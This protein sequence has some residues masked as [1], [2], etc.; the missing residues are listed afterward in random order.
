MTNSVD[1]RLQRTAEQSAATNLRRRS[2][3]DSSSTS[4]SR[5]PSMNRPAT[6]QYL[7]II[8]YEQDEVGDA[9][10]RSMSKMK[11][12]L[13]QT[14]TISSELESEIKVDK[15]A[16]SMA[17]YSKLAGK[18][19][20]RDQALQERVAQNLS[21]SKK[22][23][24]S[25]DA[26]SSLQQ[27]MDKLP[28]QLKE[29]S[30]A[31]KDLAKFMV[32]NLVN[33]TDT[34]N[35][36]AGLERDLAVRQISI[37]KTQPNLRM[38]QANQ[39]IL[40]ASLAYIQSNQPEVLA[41]LKSDQVEQVQSGSTTAQAMTQY[42]HQ[43]LNE[44]PDDSTYLDIFK[45]N[46]NG[47][48][49]SD[50]YA[51]KMSE[52]IAKRIH[53]L[54]SQAA[55][56]AKN[57]N[58]IKLSPEEAE[59][60]ARTVRQA[61]QNLHGGDTPRSLERIFSQI[62]SQ[63][64]AT[65]Q[66]QTTGQGQ[67]QAQAP[68]PNQ[69]ASAQAQKPA[70]LSNTAVNVDPTDEMTEQMLAQVDRNTKNENVR[71]LSLAELSARA[72][73]L[74]QQF[75]AERQRL[76]AEGKLPNPAQM[77]Q[78]GFERQQQAANVLNTTLS[79]KDSEPQPLSAQQQALAQIKANTQA[80]NAA[81]QKAQA[82]ID[83]SAAQ[84][85]QAQAQ[86][87][88]QA[89][90]RPAS[91]TITTQPQAQPQPQAQQAQGQQA[92][93]SQPAQS[94]APATSSATATA[95]APETA[96]A[97]PKGTIAQQGSQPVQAQP[98]PQAQAQPQVHEPK[99]QAPAA[100]QIAID[101][102]LTTLTFD[103]NSLRNTS[104]N[105]SYNAV[106]S[107]IYGG[108]DIMPGMTIPVSHF[109]DLS[110]EVIQP[111]QK[112]INALKQQAQF[113]ETLAQQ[114]QAPSNKGETVAQSQVQQPTHPVV[115]DGEEALIAKQPVQ[116]APQQA[117][118]T[119]Q[120]VQQ[121]VAAAKGSLPKGPLA[122]EQQAQQPAQPQVQQPARPVVADGEETLVAKQPVQ[123]APQQAQQPQQSVQQQVAA[124]Q[125]SLPKGPV[126]TEQQAQQPA[127]PQVQQPARPVVADGEEALVAKQ[128]VQQAPQQQQPQQSV[129]QQVAAA[130]GSLPKGHIATEQQAQQPAAQPQVQQPA[131]PVV[132][133]GEET[134][135]A[136]QP[137]Q[138][139]PQQQQPHQSVQQQV[140]AAQG[141][142]P[143]GHIA[144]EQQ[145]QQPAQPQV[146]QPA[147]PVV[148]DGE[149]TLVA[150]QPV[151]QAPQQAQQP[152]QQQPQQSVQQQVAAAQDALPKGPIATEQQAQ[153]Q[154]PAVQPQ[155]QQA[156][157]QPQQ[158]AAS[159]PPVTLANFKS[160]MYA[161]LYGQMQKQDYEAAQI[162]QPT[163][164][165][166]ALHK[167]MAQVQ[168]DQDV[169][170]DTFNRLES[171]I[172]KRQAQSTQGA[173]SAQGNQGAGAANANAN[174]N[175]LNAIPAKAQVEFNLDL[176]V[177]KQLF[178]NSNT[179]E[180]EAESVF[181]AKQAAS[182]A[183]ASA[184]ASGTEALAAEDDQVLA[185]NK[186]PH[187]AGERLSVAET[188]AALKQEKA[189][190]E[191]Q[192]Q[193]EQNLRA[194]A[195]TIANQERESALMAPSVVLDEQAQ[196]QGLPEAIVGTATGQQA[197]LAGSSAPQTANTA[198]DSSAL[199]QAPNPAAPHDADDSRMQ[200]LYEHVQQNLNEA[201]NVRAEAMQTQTTIAQER[202]QA[203]IL[204]QQQQQQQAQQQQ[205]VQAAADDKYQNT[206][207]QQAQLT[208]DQRATGGNTVGNTTIRATGTTLARAHSDAVTSQNQAQ[209][210]TTQVEART[211]GA[212]ATANTVTAEARA[213]QATVS[214][215]AVQQT[216][217]HQVTT[218]QTPA[219]QV[220]AQSQAPTSA[221]SN[222]ASAQSA[223][224]PAQ[225]TT[226]ASM[227]TPMP[228][229]QGSA[230]TANA[231]ASAAP[232]T[233]AA[234][235]T[236]VATPNAATMVP[237]TATGASNSSTVAGM[238]TT[239]SP[240]ISG[241]TATSGVGALGSTTSVGSTT[242]TASATGTG[243]AAGTA[244]ANGTAAMMNQLSGRSSQHI[245]HADLDEESLQDEIIKNVM[246]TVPSDELD[247]FSLRN[248]NI[249][250]AALS[251]VIADT[252]LTSSAESFDEI[253][254]H[255]QAMP[256]LQS[257]ATVVP[258]NS[259]PG[260]A[261]ITAGQNA[262]IPDESVIPNMTTPKEGGGLLRRLAS[263]FG[264][265]A[266]DSAETTAA[267][268]NQAVSSTG[269][270]I[271]P[272]ERT[273][274]Q[275]QIS[276]AQNAQFSAL[277]QL[278]ARLQGASQDPALPP[279]MQE[280]AQKLLRALQNPVADL[281]S[282]SNWLNFITGPLSPSSSQALALHQW[283]FMLLCIRFEQIGKNVER[284]LKKSSS[285]S[286][287]KE[288]DGSIKSNRGLFESLNDDGLQKSQ[289]LLKDTFNQ[290]ERLQQQMQAVP[291]GQVLPRVIPLPPYYHGG[292][293]GSMSAHR[294]Q[295]ED[296]GTSWNLNFNLDLENMG[297]L[298]IKVRL[299]FPEVQMSFVAE[300]LETLQ[301]VQENMPILNARLQEVGL[302][303]KG[304]NARLGHVSLQDSRANSGSESKSDFK[305]EGASFNTRA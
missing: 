130:Q 19:I 230:P 69:A 257:T 268:T 217:A 11:Q 299:R 151:Q 51:D 238:G 190:A 31:G 102:D 291:T 288:L 216:P 305:F 73:Q 88:A 187:R 23:V 237:S 235:A 37:P 65:T 87:Q 246:Q 53:D 162:K 29:G 116:Q 173:P 39:K 115:A 100:P 192:L 166:P 220:A 93:T 303:S 34:K 229:A 60:F 101:N 258:T 72:A 42:L 99:G 259:T 252:D 241:L 156:P 66:A 96:Q 247:A 127:Q 250:N 304:S 240:E 63:N 33:L 144:T 124:A 281:Q 188:V 163:V 175:G 40:A 201:R 105:L 161:R 256:P 179:I 265:R 135:V 32:E 253:L 214:Q 104:I 273:E 67:A 62:N 239:A 279:Q 183:M 47:Q 302:T 8:S 207:Q 263:I 109:G 61:Q 81:V 57:G 208:Q 155:V 195:E 118:Q 84:Y 242:S 167:Q 274:L 210:G 27:A 280:Q 58:L 76:V 164:A 243:A 271:S 255:N 10:A 191:E 7:N 249:G 97:A 132:A 68:A 86:N 170:Q 177:A 82:A 189:E 248:G 146:Q 56:T 215:P 182:Q 43:A 226:P 222:P 4:T 275:Q 209:V 133:D 196:I 114:Q 143:K 117:Q 95:P 168:A 278:F 254:R 147:R 202:A 169:V 194:K 134:L 44:F 272:S 21:T 171:L 137:V 1:P 24:R 83:K 140:A 119:Q 211:T 20:N 70:N 75:R 300:K 25:R 149:E 160:N 85:A 298:Q 284:F 128:P 236:T 223:T 285:N 153:A 90:G 295:D 205:Q 26:A 35:M 91:P 213:Q 107:S 113:L 181:A 5:T 122:T 245:I 232:A 286:E 138:Q 59:N 121:Q 14:A 148:A 55:T 228:S 126:A 9:L 225:S 184:K 261:Q 17:V 178:A 52:E 197:G 103:Q 110:N 193:R 18:I 203:Q 136:K 206:Q 112:A 16:E 141:S 150:K 262:P 204:T 123:Q 78:S 276:R 234:P 159:E 98:Q 13:S 28:P 2:S 50:G 219:Q 54:I 80:L 200:R 131:R 22:L 185:S 158:P 267:T 283:A 294:E 15:Q 71:A 94:P 157:Q 172:A 176:D 77:P 296:G 111:N 290:V 180:A 165:E 152:Q 139:A 64:Q 277:D 221:G 244:A 199:R 287:I 36:G 233:P 30:A 293:E 129:Q 264:R 3:G 89:Q 41:T 260:A 270:S 212:G 198:Q 145:A 218:Q 224:A 174:A 154:Q 269:M 106:Q 48:G 297:A 79:S 38:Q 231:P 6:T 289:E 120:S 125:G 142:L 12:S 45:Q 92:V 227:S 301:K 49:N 266:D 46:R 74:Q 108:L 292:K 282:V 186:Q 251:G